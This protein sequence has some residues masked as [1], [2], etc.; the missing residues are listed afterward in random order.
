MPICFLLPYSGKTFEGENFHEFRGFVAIHES[1]LCEI[2][3]CGILWCGKSEQSAKVFYV[4]I[5]FFT[6]WQSFSAIRY[7]NNIC[8]LM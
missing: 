2:W 1:F 3:G 4:K 7:A 6:N 5:V 8:E